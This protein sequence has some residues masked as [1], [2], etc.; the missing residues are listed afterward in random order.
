[1]NADQKKKLEQMACEAQ[2]AYGHLL[3]GDGKRNGAKIR[4]YGTGYREGLQAAWELA[5]SMGRVGELCA[6]KNE[7]DADGYSVALGLGG[8]ET[9]LAF[10]ARLSGLNLGQ[11]KERNRIMEILNKTSYHARRNCP[12]WLAIAIKEILK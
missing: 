3:E 4:S 6:L 10:K 11:I 12:S 8:R 7:E 1:M 9:V 5:Q 2:L